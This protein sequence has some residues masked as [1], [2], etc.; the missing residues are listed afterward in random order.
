MV[1]GFQIIITIVAHSRHEDTH[2]LLLSN[3]H[4]HVSKVP[5]HP[6][7]SAQR[8]PRE[9]QRDSDSLPSAPDSHKK[10]VWEE[11]LS[12]SPRIILLHN[13]ATQAE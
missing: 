7:G 13:F 11:V 1:A 2:D 4:R 10:K 8:A 12:T 3:G 5:M 9:Q 6:L